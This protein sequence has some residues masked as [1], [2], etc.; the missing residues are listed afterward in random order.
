MTWFESLI[1]LDK[2]LL[3]WGNSFH[4][5]FWDNFI[6]IFS[7]KLIWI[8]TALMLL[9]VIVRTEKRNSW[10]VLLFLIITVVLS[11]QISSGIIKPLV[12][13]WRPTHEPTLQGMVQLVHGYTG[14]CYGFVSSH[15]ANSFALALFTSLLFRRKLYT[16]TIF[17]WATANV[18]TRIYLGVHYPLDI[19][20]GILLGLACGWLSFYLMQRLK[21]ECR[22]SRSTEQLD[23][24][25]YLIISVLFISVLLIAVGNKFLLFLA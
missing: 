23:K 14:G 16:W 2:Q 24:H 13:R 25:I 17:L 9:Y 22:Q 18:Y 15:A 3:L 6:Y 12:A 11:D 8:P 4:S 21:P 5:P 7:G 1:E 10:W 19:L 20:G